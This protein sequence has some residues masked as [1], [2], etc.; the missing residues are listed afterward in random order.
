MI[1]SNVRPPSSRSWNNIQFHDKLYGVYMDVI[2]SLE[3]WRQFVAPKHC[4]QPIILFRSKNCE[5]II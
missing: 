3:K 5:T 4:C 1:Q 2:P